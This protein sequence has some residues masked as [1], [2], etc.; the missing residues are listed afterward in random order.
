MLSIIK[1]NP[2]TKAED[3][4]NSLGYMFSPLSSVLNQTYIVA[5]TDNNMIN[6]IPVLIIKNIP[7]LP[8]YF[9]VLILDLLLLPY[10]LVYIVLARISILSPSGLSTL[11]PTLCIPLNRKKWPV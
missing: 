10:L 9:I 3:T 2:N 4:A 7:F 8:F 5:N 6:P 1:I 11:P